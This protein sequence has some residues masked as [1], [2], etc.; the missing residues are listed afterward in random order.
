MTPSLKRWLRLVGGLAL[1]TLAVLWMTH[2]IDTAALGSVFDPFPYGGFL[3][4]AAVMLTNFGLRAT[5]W[6]L[7]VRAVRK[8]APWWW[9]TVALFSGAAVN[10]LVPLRFGDAVRIFAFPRIGLG[11]SQLMGTLVTERV[12]DVWSL[13]GIATLSVSLF[14]G[15]YVPVWAIVLAW[16]IWVAIGGLIVSMRWLQIE[17]LVAVLQDGQSRW[18][19]M[20]GVVLFD[21]QTA[22]RLGSGRGTLM[23]VMT[24]SVL[25]WFLEG[26]AFAIAMKVTIPH[27]PW[28]LSW[29][30]MGT[31]TLATMVPA[32]P[33]FIGTFD[34]AAMQPP[35]WAGAGNAEAAAF[36]I[37]VHLVVWVPI[38][39]LGVGLG[40]G[41]LL[42]GQMDLRGLR[43]TRGSDDAA[44]RLASES[45]ES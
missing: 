8:E 25:A 9:C 40:L 37:L 16:I 5:R 32:A 7:L 24:L 42:Q 12:L 6:W 44:S 4:A 34:V 26:F 27:V 43:R 17:W 39:A 20:L 38:T 41:A 30:S 35:I 33:G 21:V 23:P 29:A 45:G 13:V 31:A 1:A 2:N 10:N 15:T 22:I 11:A 28:G 36:A 3:V 14:L 19:Q 18:R